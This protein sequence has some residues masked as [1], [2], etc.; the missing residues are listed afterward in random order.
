[1]SNVDNSDGDEVVDIVIEP[2]SNMLYK[3]KTLQDKKEV[4]DSIAAIKADPDQTLNVETHLNYILYFLISNNK[5]PV[6]FKS[7]NAISPW[8]LYWLICSLMTLKDPPVSMGPGMTLE[9]IMSKIKEETLLKLRKFQYNISTQLE[10]DNDEPLHSGFSGA[11]MQIPHLA[12]TFAS[13]LTLKLT[14]N[15]DQFD[16]T[17]IKQW[18]MDLMSKDKRTGAYELKTSTPIGEFDARAFYC[19][20][21]SARLCQ[22]DLGLE[23]LETIWDMLINSQSDLEG[24]LNGHDKDQESHGAYAFCTLSSIIIVLDQLR[25]LKP[26]KYKNKR[27]HDFINID[28]FIDWLAHRQDAVNGGL[29]GR[30]NK[31][32]DGC[33]AYWVGACGSILKIYGYI[34][35]INM[36][37]LKSYILN[38]SQDNEDKNPGLRDKPGM[39]ADFYHTNYILMGLSLCEYE[40]DMYLPDAYSDAMDI[41]CNELK[42]KQVHGVNPVYG[43]PVYVIAQLE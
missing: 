9:K 13:V 33:Y 14:N 18:F 21:V 11:F 5:L 25:V 34:N 16:F 43:L 7:M 32:V 23:Y 3:S 31:L 35:P 29:S 28:K 15:L 4:D 41:R 19:L 37:M 8:I 22:I 2:Y 40:N 6:G 24:G 26:E 39:N 42:G 38:Y 17:D 30:H 27:L 36:S 10:N 12:P 20:L 1:M